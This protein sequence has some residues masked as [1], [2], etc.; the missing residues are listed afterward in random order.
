MRG[1]QHTS[2][3]RDGAGL[4]TRF[5]DRDGQL[6]ERQIDGDLRPVDDEPA[7]DVLPTFASDAR[8]EEHPHFRAATCQSCWGEHVGGIRPRSRIGRRYLP[9]KEGERR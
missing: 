5:R 3:S 9:P 7:A 4:V 6:V 1:H 2:S 8:C